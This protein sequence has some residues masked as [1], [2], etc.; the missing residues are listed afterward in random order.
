MAVSTDSDQSQSELYDL[1]GAQRITAVIYTAAR[2]GVADVLADG[3]K[4]SRE[5][6]KRTGAHEASLRRLL[7]ALVA[8]GVCDEV[9][10]D[11][12]A[13]TAVG[14]HLAG[15]AEKSLKAWALFEGELLTRSWVSLIDS[16]RTGKTAA[17]LANVGNTFDLMA[18]DP[19]VVKTFNEAMVA[20]TRTVVP[21]LL[22]AYDFAGI[23]CLM[24][25]GGGYGELLCA[26][27]AAHP[28]M[29]GVI[30][31]LA[32]CEE[33]ARREIE[34][35][36]LG[37]RAEFV[38]GSFFESVP[39]GAD[40]IIMKSIIHDWNDERSIAI[41]RNCRRALPPAGKLLLVEREMPEVVDA[42]A[43]HRAVTLSDLNM[44]RGPGGAERTEKEY[45]GLLSAGGFEMKRLVAAGRMGLIESIVAQ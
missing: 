12:F 14:A 15:G 8:I 21:G 20:F 42:S 32:R 11:S 5:I 26:V 25:V 18:R 31:D 19:E 9:A 3:A 33:G 44:L 13:L 35:A 28:S 17:E 34:R 4:S 6:A 43:D 27:L 23:G 36:R 39:G 41:L 1:I 45:R 10:S 16:I 30:F 22:A 40:A 29:R 37:H 24:D 38:S 2:L 7:R